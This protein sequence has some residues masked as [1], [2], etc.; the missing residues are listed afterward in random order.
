VA[1]TVSNP[2]TGS[3]K[4]SSVVASVATS[5][6]TAWTA[7]TGCSALDYTVGTPTITYG[8]IA[9]GSTLSGTVTITMNDR[10]SA[11]DACKN[12]AVPI[13]FAAS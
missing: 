6:G 11:Q 8:E 12:V 5:T 4:L 1:F 13:Y 10:A 7:V 9:G 3:E 2:G